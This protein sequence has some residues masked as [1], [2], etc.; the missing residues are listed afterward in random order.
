ML[1][2]CCE[3]PR[4]VLEHGIFP[5]FF[6]TRQILQVQGSQEYTQDTAVLTN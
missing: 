5:E 4:E 3:F 2:A 6:F 1:K